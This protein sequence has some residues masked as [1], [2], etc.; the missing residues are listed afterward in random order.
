M[1]YKASGPLRSSRLLSVPRIK[2]KQSEAAFVFYAPHLRNKFPEYRSYDFC[3]HGITDRIT[4]LS[5]IVNMEYHRTDRNLTKIQLSSERRT[6]IL[7]EHS[8]RVAN[9]WDHPYVTSQT[10]SPHPKQC[11]H[12]EAAAAASKVGKKTNKKK[13]VTYPKIQR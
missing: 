8:G 5:N 3:D 10:L 9:A 12:V 13:L 2:T 6:F 4:E 11:K 7:G 1:R